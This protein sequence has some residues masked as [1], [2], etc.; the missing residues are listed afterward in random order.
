MADLFRLREW[1]TGLYRLRERL[2]VPCLLCRTRAP[3]GLCADCKLAIHGLRSP[4][5]PRC[6]RCSV[7][8]GAFESCP[9]CPTLSPALERVVAAFD[10]SWPG[11][12][13]IQQLKLQGRYGCAPVLACLLAE[14][15]QGLE[16]A[17]RPG[18]DV[19]VVA[20]PASRRALRLRGYNPAAELGRALAHRLGLAWRPDLITRMREGERQ[21]GRS[22]RLRRHGV[23]GLYRCTVP[24]AGRRVLLVDDVMT[25][26]STLDAIARELH[27][28]G[29]VQI[30]G[31][32]AARTPTARDASQ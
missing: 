14:R 6:P 31:A 29:A 13:L 18:P 22:R 16:F 4:A 7:A 19:W 10:Y 1:R 21:T 12:L 28:R 3:G 17:L 26:G 24:V 23:E 9:D 32:V 15:C 8:L 20:V 2:P 11:E 30:I 27:Q 25:T 5:N